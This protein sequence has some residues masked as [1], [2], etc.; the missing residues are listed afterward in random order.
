MTRL[1]SL[2]ALLAL[3]V[4]LVA[5]AHPWNIAHSGL[6]ITADATVQTDKVL[7]VAQIPGLDAV[8]ARLAKTYEEELVAYA[9]CSKV[10]PRPDDCRDPGTG[11]EYIE[12]HY[13]TDKT[14]RAWGRVKTGLDGVKRA[15]LTG[16]QI[17]TA[18]RDTK[19][20]P[21]GWRSI[22]DAIQEGANQVTGGL[23][24]NDV[25]VPAAWNQSKGLLAPVCN[26]IGDAVISSHDKGKQEVL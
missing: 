5:C 6:E 25:E 2:V 15:V 26:W 10:E 1:C 4:V 21:E 9:A 13:D 12:A 19:T 20:Q 18:W 16:E 22:C 24:E 7:A 3:A 17:V 23:E 8:K 14:V 11:E